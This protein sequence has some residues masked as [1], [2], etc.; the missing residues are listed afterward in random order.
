VVVD[1][2]KGGPQQVVSVTGGTTM[3]ELRRFVMKRIAPVVSIGMALVTACFFLTG[4]PDRSAV[5]AGSGT[6]DA[7]SAAEADPG[8]GPKPGSSSRPPAADTGSG[9]KDTERPGSGTR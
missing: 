4:C 9:T 3:A 8:S 2:I 5:P 1:P 6:R 7:A